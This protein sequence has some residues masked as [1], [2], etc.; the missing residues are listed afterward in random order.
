MGNEVKEFLDGLRGDL[1][2]AID[3][4]PGDA[5]VDKA[6]KAMKPDGMS[7]EDWDKLSPEEQ[8]FSV[9]REVQ[10]ENMSAID[11]KQLVSAKSQELIRRLQTEIGMT[12]QEAE[13]LFGVSKSKGFSSLFS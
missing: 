13:K 1:Q 5:E 9:L 3:G 8:A 12:V 6:A 7:Q 4:M 11:P 10:S 2:K